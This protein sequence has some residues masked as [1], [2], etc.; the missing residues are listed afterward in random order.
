[1][2]NVSCGTCPYFFKLENQCRAKPPNGIPIQQGP[3]GQF[4]FIGF[5]PPTRDSNWCG[6]HP[7]FNAKVTIIKDS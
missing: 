3:A 2:Q 7:D 5:W 1:M 6:Q 4:A